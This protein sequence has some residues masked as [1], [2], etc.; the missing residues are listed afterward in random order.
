MLEQVDPLTIFD[1]GCNDYS[2]PLC[3]R[4]V[5]KYFDV[6]LRSLETENCKTLQHIFG[7]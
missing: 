2:S 7:G 4:L 3:F 1:A 5:S 6:C